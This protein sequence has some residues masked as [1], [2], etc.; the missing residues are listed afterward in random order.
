MSYRDVQ[1]RPDSRRWQAF[2]RPILGI[3]SKTFDTQLDAAVYVAEQLSTR[4]AAQEEQE[5]EEREGEDDDKGEEG[6][7]GDGVEAASSSSVQCP[8][9]W[10]RFKNEHGLNIHLGKRGCTQAQRSAAQRSEPERSVWQPEVGNE[11]EVL[12][13]GDDFEVPDTYI[14]EVIGAVYIGEGG[15]DYC[16]VKYRTLSSS[17]EEMTPLEEE[18]EVSARLTPSRPDPDQDFFKN[19]DKGDRVDVYFEVEGEAQGAAGGWWWATVQRTTDT[20]ITVELNDGDLVTLKCPDGV[21]KP[22]TLERVSEEDPRTDSLPADPEHAPSTRLRPFLLFD[23]SRAQWGRPPASTRVAREDSQCSQED[24]QPQIIEGDEEAKINEMVKQYAAKRSYLLG[25]HGITSTDIQTAF[26]LLRSKRFW[27]RAVSH[28]QLRVTA[29]AVAYIMGGSESQATYA[30]EFSTGSRTLSA[31]TV[32]IVQRKLRAY[33]FKHNLSNGGSPPTKRRCSS[34]RLRTTPSSTRAPDNNRNPFENLNTIA[35]LESALKENSGLMNRINEHLAN[36]LTPLQHQVWCSRDPSGRSERLKL[37]KKLLREGAD[38]TIRPEGAYPS[39]QAFRTTLEIAQNV[40]AVLN[41]KK[42]LQLLEKFGDSEEDL[43]KSMNAAQPQIQHGR[44]ERGDKRGLAILWLDAQEALP[45]DPALIQLQKDVEAKE[46]EARQSLSAESIDLRRL[47]DAVEALKEV[48]ERQRISELDGGVDEQLPSKAAD[49]LTK[50]LLKHLNGFVQMPELD[51]V[52]GLGDSDPAEAMEQA[53]RFMNLQGQQASQMQTLAAACTKVRELCQRVDHSRDT[54]HR[55]LEGDAGSAHAEA[56]HELLP[57]VCDTLLA[58]GLTSLAELQKLGSEVGQ[59]SMAQEL[60]EELTAIVTAVEPARSG[61]ATP[62]QMR[63]LTRRAARNV[64][65][66]MWLPQGVNADEVLELVRRCDETKAGRKDGLFNPGDGASRRVL[67]FSL[68]KLAH[69]TSSTAP[70]DDG[71]DEGLVFIERCLRELEGPTPEEFDSMEHHSAYV[72]KNNLMLRLVGPSKSGKSELAKLLARL[73]V[74]SAATP[75]DGRWMEMEQ[76]TPDASR[77]TVWT[78][79]SLTSETEIWG[80]LKYLWEQAKKFEHARFALVMPE[81]N[82]GDLFNILNSCWFDPRNAIRPDEPLAASQPPPNL[83]II[84]TE[85]PE[86]A[87][88]SF[89]VLGGDAALLTRL[90]R[91][92]TAALVHGVPDIGDGEGQV[93]QELF[94]SDLYLNMCDLGKHFCVNKGIVGPEAQRALGALKNEDHAR[95][96]ELWQ[97]HNSEPP[98]ELESFWSELRKMHVGDQDELCTLLK[99]RK[100]KRPRA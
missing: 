7:G 39:L 2:S 1:Y 76:I 57:A 98:T 51:L 45:A 87:N 24:S 6:T 14:A 9:C 16:T 37:I 61:R 33:G 92:Q 88:S 74:A 54:L 13:D 97:D 96:R 38:W 48:H 99:Q 79:K 91:R 62:Q 75:A 93:N 30:A 11:V 22:D 95:W 15:K 26:T 65:Q 42:P 4:R 19:L 36:G 28:H 71:T 12:T 70:S 46:N 81:A 40:G 49:T 85:N 41:S 69:L 3:R 10:K 80:P 56:L 94:N 73:Y 82:R 83:A 59:Y 60:A 47:L 34:E 17:E 78:A 29:A 23:P 43:R 31:P 32:S 25:R 100:D 67:C 90:T 77:H 35:D 5:K 20:E 64:L 21:W 72:A 53:Q 84:F 44:V 52:K 18:V 55:K 50:A 66:L 27:K 89:N 86:T 68:A 58:F 8:H 63:V